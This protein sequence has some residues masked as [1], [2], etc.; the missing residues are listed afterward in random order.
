MAF[1]EQFRAANPEPEKAPNF[2]AA[3]GNAAASGIEGYQKGQD[4]KRGRDKE[5]LAYVGQAMQ[6]QLDR[7]NLSAAYD[8]S[9]QARP[10]ANEIY[11]T[12]M[13]GTGDYRKPVVQQTAGQAI[14][15][16]PDGSAKIVPGTSGRDYS[17]VEWD[18]QGQANP[19]YTYDAKA[20]R[21][22]ASLYAPAPKHDY[23]TADPTK[24]VWDQ[25]SGRLVQQGQPEA[26]SPYDERRLQLQEEA[27]RLRGEAKQ[28]TDEY[29][30]QQLEIQADRLDL[31]AKR[32]EQQGQQ[33]YRPLMSPAEKDRA[34]RE[35]ATE[36]VIVSPGDAMRPPVVRSQLNEQR[37]RARMQELDKLYPDHPGAAQPAGVAQPS[38]AVQA[39]R[40]LARA[41]QALASGGKVPAPAPS[42]RR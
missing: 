22:D 36:Q 14:G 8:L 23:F 4:I 18:Q 40:D 37:Y 28:A 41:A 29:R 25:G 9:E 19:R 38:G 35:F 15:R 21:A 24:N 16:N 12:N 26:M 7:G 32:L 30:R 6:Q 34:A 33:D 27:Y 2:W 42:A 1:L 3:L 13:V 20:L 5:R 39:V 10:L 17:P 11:G 31:T